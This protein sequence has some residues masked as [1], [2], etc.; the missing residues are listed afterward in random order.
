MKLLKT[1]AISLCLIA[2]AGSLAC[3]I[4][5]QTGTQLQTAAAKGNISV[6]VN[7]TGKA[8][9]ASDAKLAFD[10]AG[11]VELLPVKKGDTVTKGA[12]LA[13]LDTAN[14]ELSLSEAK[15]SAAQAQKAVTQ[16]QISV[17]QAQV[18]LSQAQSAQTQAESAVTTAQFNLD[19]IE[20]VGDIKDQIMDI[21]IAI[22]TA[23][24]NRRIASATDDN[25]ALAYLNQ[26]LAELNN[27]LDKK[28]ADLQKL[29][30]KDEYSGVATY[31]LMTFDAATQTYSLGGQTYNRLV[32][33]DI[34][35]KQ[36]TLEIAQAGVIE[37]EQNIEQADQNVELADQTVEQAKLS[38]DQAN[39][40]VQVAQDQLVHATI[41]APFDGII[42][43]LDVEQ[44]DYIVT[45]GLSTGTPIYMVNPASLEISTKIDEIDIA[46]VKLGQKTLMSL[47]ALPGE[48]FNGVVTAIST[49]PINESS[50][51]GVV[52]YEVTI[53]FNGAPPAQIKSGMS[54][55]VDILTE[56]KQGV[57]LVPNKSIKTNNQGQKVI[58]VLVNQKTQEQP[59]VLGITD[60]TQTEVVSGIH[61]GDVVISSP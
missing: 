55:N 52:E 60:G 42:T 25:S 23:Q 48:Q 27:E 40:A 43:T 29:L 54:A 39:Q 57:I 4:G 5:Q 35:I 14:L 50:T 44:G 18:N 26:H 1:L 12:V 33:E 45:P 31:E 34:Q 10:T 9:Y 32:V 8:S 6:K 53:G 30:G 51:S 11:K 38:L 37:A 49:I 17:T 61:E 16:A 3:S 46:G 24:E 58:N 59:V 13:K 15:V 2:L 47:E 21:E 56:E 22:S 41:L 19:Q 20:D 28:N 36:K 7:G